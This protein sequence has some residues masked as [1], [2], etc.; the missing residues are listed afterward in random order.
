MMAR[1]LNING[2]ADWEMVAVKTTRGKLILE[3]S[4]V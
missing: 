2:N 3:K 1:A 4:S